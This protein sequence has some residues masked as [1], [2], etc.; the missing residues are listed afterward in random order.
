[1]VFSAPRT[2]DFSSPGRRFLSPVPFFFGF[3]AGSEER[4]EE[5]KG[6]FSLSLSL[7]CCFFKLLTLHLLYWWAESS[8]PCL[9]LNIS[10]GCTD[11]LGLQLSVPPYTALEISRL[12]LYRLRVSRVLK[13]GALT[14]RKLSPGNI[15]TL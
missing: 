4:T 1:M 5:E 13:T 9:F 14:T 15:C 8:R 11:V 10:L 6:T 3:P 12:I 7:L 2:H